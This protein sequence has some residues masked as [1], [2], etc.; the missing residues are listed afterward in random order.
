MVSVDFFYLRG[1]NDIFIYLSFY[2]TKIIR[3]TRVRVE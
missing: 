2:D 3:N 1:V